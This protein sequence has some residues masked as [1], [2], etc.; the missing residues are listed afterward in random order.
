M[1]KCKP[2]RFYMG[3][4]WP[5]QCVPEISPQKSFQTILG[6]RRI[7]FNFAQRAR[8][9]SFWLRGV[10]NANELLNRI[11]INETPLRPAIFARASYS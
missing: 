1:K 6:E 3:I 2:I 11:R 9:K 8:D 7:A 5:W 4:S 10:D